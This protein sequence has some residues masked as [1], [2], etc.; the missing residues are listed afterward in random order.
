MYSI[1]RRW[2]GLV[3]ARQAF[4]SKFP[5]VCRKRGKSQPGNTDIIFRNDV[6]VF[7]PIASQLSRRDV[8]KFRFV[9]LVPFRDLCALGRHD[10]AK[11]KQIAPRDKFDSG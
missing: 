3:H 8:S 6:Q 7:Y 11:R 10:L 9:F 4:A 5:R 1:V 2:P